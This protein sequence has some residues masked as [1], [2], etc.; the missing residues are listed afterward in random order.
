M[1]RAGTKGE[2]TRSMILKRAFAM[3]STVGLEGLTIGNVAKEAEM[4]K[5]G[6]YAHFESKE[7]LQLQ[8]LE[9]A[10]QRFIDQVTRPIITLPRGEP[11]VRA[12]FDNWRR[13]ARGTELPGGCVF[14]SAAVELDDRPGPLRDYFVET[15]RQALQAAARAASIAVDE[16]HFRADLDVEQFAHDLYSIILV[17]H[18]FD[19]LFDDP[20]AAERALRSFDELMARSRS[21]RSPGSGPH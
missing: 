6:V 19:R 14:I 9:T 2:E 1:T 21:P 4:S 7:E 10:V 12:F 20:K 18:H 8:V 11:R 5:S 16:G 13:W 3:A 17:Y 15:Q